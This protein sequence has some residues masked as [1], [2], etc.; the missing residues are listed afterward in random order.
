M[1][2]VLLFIPQAK[3][4]VNEPLTRKY[5]QISRFSSI[6]C[7]IVSFLIFQFNFNLSCIHIHIYVTIPIYPKV[8]HF[9][10]SEIF[11]NFVIFLTFFS[12]GK[13]EQKENI[14]IS[15]FLH[16]SNFISENPL[17]H[18]QRDNARQRSSTSLNFFICFSNSKPTKVFLFRLLRSMEPLHKCILPFHPRF[19]RPS[20]FLF[21]YTFYL[22]PSFSLPEKILFCFTMDQLLTLT[23]FDLSSFSRDLESLIAQNTFSRSLD[24]HQFLQFLPLFVSK[25]SGNIILMKNLFFFFFFFFFQTFRLK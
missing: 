1:S 18:V 21:L 11:D 6:L 2:A 12:T 5:L 19:F 24:I 8:S 4:S 10:F 20:L 17:N 3:V 23:D 22:S 15:N 13:T 16:R 25:Y 14:G 9:F 7:A